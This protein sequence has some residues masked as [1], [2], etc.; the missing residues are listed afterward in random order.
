MNSQDC[1]GDGHLWY[2]NVRKDV[3]LV[4][5]NQDSV[6]VIMVMGILLAQLHK[7]FDSS[8]KETFY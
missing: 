8:K 2:N 1:C 6:A 3:S 5:H 7:I 4:K